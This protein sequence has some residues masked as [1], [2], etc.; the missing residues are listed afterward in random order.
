MDNYGLPP[1]MYMIVF[2]V[3]LLLD[4]TILRSFLKPGGAAVGSGL[5]VSHCAAGPW[6]LRPDI[7]GT[8]QVWTLLTDVAFALLHSPERSS[9]LL[10]CLCLTFKEEMLLTRHLDTI[11]ML[12]W[13]I[14][15]NLRSTRGKLSSFLKLS[16][17]SHCLYGLNSCYLSWFSYQA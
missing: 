15:L 12:F 10:S 1:V 17:K 4:T 8:V 6:A 3:L 9:T 14:N 2:S 16:A 7:S 5:T 13:Q 11:Q